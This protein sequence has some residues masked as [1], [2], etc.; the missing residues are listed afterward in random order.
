MTCSKVHDRKLKLGHD[1]QALSVDDDRVAR[2]SQG[3]GR[4]SGAPRHA[5]L[6]EGI[7]NT[8]VQ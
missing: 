5:N 3:V 4:S 8:M 7:G 1:R 2:V 6:S